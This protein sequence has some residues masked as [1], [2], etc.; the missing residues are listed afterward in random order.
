MK[1]I[2][3][4]KLREVLSSKGLDEG[5]IDRIFKRLQVAKSKSDLSKMEK[6]LEAKR[7]KLK[8]LRN[9]P[10]YKQMK[11]KYK[12]QDVPGIDIPADEVD[13]DD[14]FKTTQKQI[15]KIIGK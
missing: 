15:Q 5:F 9:D 11:K 3:R 1:T 6:D 10:E 8:Q 4:T 14:F 2:K 13:L 12:L 7:S